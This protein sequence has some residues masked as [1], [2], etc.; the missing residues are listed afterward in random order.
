MECRFHERFNELR[1]AIFK[2][3][4]IRLYHFDIIWESKVCLE[5]TIGI[6]RFSELSG[7]CQ[8]IK[9]PFRHDDSVTNKSQIV[10]DA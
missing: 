8:E 7:E 4:Y 6:S 5:T 2:H 10:F 3:I 9:S 1:R